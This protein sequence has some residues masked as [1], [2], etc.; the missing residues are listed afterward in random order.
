MIKKTIKDLSINCQNILGWKSNKKI[1]VIESDDWGSIRMPSKKAY[2]NLLNNGIAVDKCPYNSNDSLENTDDLNA[3]FETFSSIKDSEG[4]SL[5]LTA[6][7][8]LANPDFE[9]IKAN[10][11]EK[12]Y[13]EDFV[14]TYQRVNGNT[15]TYELI[16]QGLDQGVYIPQLHG[17]EHLQVN[18]WLNILREGDKEALLAFDNELFGYPTQRYRDSKMHL[19]TA[20]HIR[21]PEEEKFAIQSIRESANLFEQFF[22][23]KSESFIA[24][25]YIWNDAVEDELN[26]CGVKYIQGK[27]VQ[28]IPNEN[29]LKSKIH[30][31]GS[32]NKYDQIY[33]NRNVF[34]E[35]TQNPRFPW[36]KDA[37]NRIDISF[38]WGKPAII[39]MHRLN[40]MGGLN[41]KNRT[42]NLLALKDLINKVQKKY[43]DVIFMSTNELGKLINNEK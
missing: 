31:F 5:K 16:K 32:K 18:E 38:R 22:G 3:L 9:K 33:L 7:S 14:S 21:N 39:S 40:F 2:S 4:N 13:Y 35:P 25:R 41:E 17:R 1:L 11:F 19:L 29:S 26:N 6:N 42:D 24:P 27:I 12:Y 8:I 20:L 10:N 30:L 36:I 28:S 23:F 15:E 37:L 34:F 43:P